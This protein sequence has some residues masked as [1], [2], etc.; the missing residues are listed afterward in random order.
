[1]TANAFFDT[2]ILI[3][4]L[5]VR[6]S[7]RQDPRSEIAEKTLSPGGVVSVQVLNELADVVTCRFQ[8]GWDA[9]EQYLEV[10]N[11]LCG[12]AVPLT[13]ETQMAAIEISRRYGYRIYD[14]LILAAA[15]Q[16]GCETVFTEDMQHGQKIGGMTIVNPFIGL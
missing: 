8:K 16:T 9:I 12:R 2:N 5:T 7:S 14:S 15:R 13:V 11:A 4:A 6:A 10:V 1:M 3:Y